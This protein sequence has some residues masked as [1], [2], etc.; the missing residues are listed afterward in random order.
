MIHKSGFESRTFEVLIYEVL[1]RSYSA[2]SFHFLSSCP[3]STAL[4][5]SMACALDQS[6][7]FALGAFPAADAIDIW[8]RD[9]P[10]ISSL[11]FHG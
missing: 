11:G 7:D 10:E 5:V 6:V 2:Q 1:F 4:H 9:S 3:L 8:A